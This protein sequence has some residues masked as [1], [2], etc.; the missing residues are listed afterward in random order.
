M[1]SGMTTNSMTD[2]VRDDRAIVGVYDDR[3]AAE[4]AVDARDSARGAGS[5]AY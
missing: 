1:A 3:M 2:A 5:Q 4:A